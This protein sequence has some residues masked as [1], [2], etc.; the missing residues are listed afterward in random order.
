MPI[1][2]DVIV[3]VSPALQQPLPPQKFL[4]AG[5]AEAVELVRAAAER[6]LSGGTGPPRRASKPGAGPLRG[7]VTTKVIGI[8]GA[9]V[10]GFIRSGVFYGRFLETGAAA[11]PIE[12]THRR[13]RTAK[14][15]GPGMLAFGDPVSPTF[16]RTVKH[17]GIRARYWMRS[18]AEAQAPAVVARLTRAT[19]QWTTAVHAQF[20]QQGV[21]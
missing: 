10:A 21:G 12:A 19:T 14:Q 5:M 4:E 17:P 6:N 8:P 20:Q 3:R 16:R 7:S 2:I 1:A 11:H 9:G 13:A 18:A 15:P